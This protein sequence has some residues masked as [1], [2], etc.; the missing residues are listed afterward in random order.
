MGRFFGLLVGIAMLQIAAHC[1]SQRVA[2]RKGGTS[3]TEPPGPRALAYLSTAVAAQNAQSRWS[4]AS[5]II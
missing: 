3:K 2:A 4:P 1:V 5:S